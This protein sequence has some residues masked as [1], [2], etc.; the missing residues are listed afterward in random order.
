MRC[1][2]WR[3]REVVPV[4]SLLTAAEC[5]DFETRWLA[6]RFAYEWAMAEPRAEM[7]GHL[8]R[9]KATGIPV[10]L[11]HVETY[12]AAQ[13]R[14]VEAFQHAMCSTPEIGAEGYLSA[15]AN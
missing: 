10:S 5:A 14:A 11:D 3:R 4:L 13:R 8:H 9:A 15:R 1:V 6:G 2:K 12:M 7:I